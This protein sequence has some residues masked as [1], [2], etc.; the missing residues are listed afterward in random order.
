MGPEVLAALGGAQTLVPAALSLGGMLMQQGAMSD[1]EDSR[2]AS[3]NR[4][5]MEDQKYATKAQDLVQQQAK[6]YQ[7]EQR[8]QA[9]TQ[10]ED[11][12]YDSLAGRLTTAANSMPTSQ[13]AGKVSDDYL[14][15]SAK[16]TAEE[17][18]RGADTA[19]LMAK[20]RAPNDLRFSEGLSMADNAAEIGSMSND[21][22]AMRSAGG[23]D[24]QMAGQP[25]GGAMALGGL[26]QSAGTAML[27]SKLANKAKAPPVGQIDWTVDY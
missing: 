14:I 3:L 1:A 12:A 6:A 22:A 15:D 21:R 27:G 13:V 16:R 24:A 26:A 9:E 10:A 25:S 19:R 23:N 17:T 2:N 11:K 20:M 8:Q 5:L 7:P 4:M 18:Q